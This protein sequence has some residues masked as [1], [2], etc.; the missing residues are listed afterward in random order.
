MYHQKHPS[1]SIDYLIKKRAVTFSGG[2]AHTLDFF[3][4]KSL[5][6]SDEE[7][8]MGLVCLIGRP[9]ISP[10]E[11]VELF[12]GLSGSKI[13]WNFFLNGSLRV[14]CQMRK[15]KSASSDCLI[16]HHQSLIRT[17]EWQS[18]FGVVCL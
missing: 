12:E 3:K 2:L 15:H 5:I 6:V 17:E 4:N 10:S 9:N 18:A 13:P 1:C 8:D 16:C 11:S 7:V 14:T